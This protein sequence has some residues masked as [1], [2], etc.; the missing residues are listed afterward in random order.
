MPFA[1]IISPSVDNSV[2]LKS[3][4]GSDFESLRFGVPK[5]SRTF[6]FDL[7][8]SKGHEMRRFGMKGREMRPI[9]RFLLRVYFVYF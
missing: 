2:I 5:A 9:D 3:S 4:A 1:R 7:E 6:D 8:H